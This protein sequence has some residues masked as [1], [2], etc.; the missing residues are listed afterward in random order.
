M[1]IAGLDTETTGLDQSKGHR[2]VEIG[3]IVYSFDTVT[4]DYIKK[5]QYVQRINPQR[6]IDPSA[7]AVHGIRFEDV[8]GCL[9]WEVVAPKIVRLLQATQLVVAHN[10][11]GF[12][13]PFLT[14]ELLRIGSPIPDVQAVDTMLQSRWATPNGKLPNLGELCFAT[15]T[16]YDTTK[17]HSAG[18]DTEVMME[19]FFKAY[20][21][22]FIQLPE[23]KEAA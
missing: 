11:N 4:S 10:G 15:D 8:A 13:L 12:D 9:T 22:G 19:C 14:A 1:I 17:A 5:G 2:F 18:Y 6:P 16:G 7:Q 23:V 20:K 3:L 21:G